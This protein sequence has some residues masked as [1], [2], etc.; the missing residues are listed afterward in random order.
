[1]AHDTYP[2]LIDIPA[3]LR[4]ERVLL[5]PYRAGDAEHILAAV[6]ESREHLRPWVNWVDDMATVEDCRDY[7]IRCA[8]KWMLRTDLALGIF[9]ADTRQ[10]LGGTGL[11]D[12]NWELRS[13]EI[14]YW[15]RASAVGHGYV[16]EAVR[17][18]VDL[19]FDRLQARRVEL[20]CDPGNDAS[21]RVAELAGFVFEGTQRNSVVDRDGS[22]SDWLVFSL[23]PDDLDRL[24]VASPAV[25]QAAT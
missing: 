8:A 12:P 1:M 10:F 4:G 24:R 2:T 9:D 5:R 16:T 17:L 14:G 6:D 3:E 23:V 13:F 22:A 19:A 20:N 21:R 15:M 7:C 25:S 18:L 11:H